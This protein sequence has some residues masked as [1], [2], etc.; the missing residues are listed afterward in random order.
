MTRLKLRYAAP[1]LLVLSLAGC[2]A[3]DVS[4]PT[5]IEEDD[6]NNPISADLLR[7]DALAKLNVATG[8]TAFA[9]GMLADEFFADPPGFYGDFGI[10]SNDQVL[11]RRNSVAYEALLATRTVYEDAYQAWGRVRLAATVAI[12]R[13]RTYEAEVSRGAHIG[14]MFATRGFATLALA[15]NVCPGL[16]LI[17]VDG[18]TPRYGPPLS[19]EQLFNRAVED[20]D[21]ALAYATDSVRIMHFARI[22]RARA[23]LD[24]GDFAAAAA[25]VT[26][27][28]TD[29]GLYA[30]FSASSSNPL[31]FSESEPNRS[32]ADLEGGTGLD[33]VGAND[34]RVP[35]TWLAKASDS[36][37]GIYR[38]AIYATNTASILVAGG[39]EARL[40]EAEAALHA[41]QGTW[42][43]ILN[44]LRAAVSLT[45]LADPGTADARVD[46]LFRER[47]FWLFGTG[48]RLGDLRRLIDR[49]GRASES[50]L[51]TGPYRGGGVYGIA[52]SIPFPAALEQPFNAAVTGCTTR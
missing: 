30:E 8:M 33:F 45:A 40:I 18:L 36:V 47:A 52:T 28:P 38:P 35:T 31:S 1:T 5:K 25:T 34:P 7:R 19:S 29:Y 23:L 9:S 13:L 6:L 11:D 39:I 16:P 20:F 22:G 3:L 17:D 46:L 51:P 49:Y 37:S 42:L 26:T 48:H 27:V 44:D 4:N 10:V 12:P 21:S 50:V 15:E 14:Q 41:G 32:V 43:T 24:Q 2:G